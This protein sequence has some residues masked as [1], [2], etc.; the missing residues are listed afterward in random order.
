MSDDHPDADPAA[1]EGPIALDGLAYGIDYLDAVLVFH[2]GDAHLYASWVRA[3]A[4]FRAEDAVATLRDAYRVGQF[5]ARRL[6]VYSA[7]AP[8]R[9]GEALNPLLTLE[10]ASRT[11]ILRR[12]RAHVVACLFESAMPLGMARLV[13]ARLAAA[14]DPELPLDDGALPAAPGAAAAAIQIPRVQEATTEEHSPA[15]LSFG[16]G[17][18]RSLPPQR[19]S[20][21]ELDRT[22]RLLA[23]LDAHAP[24]PHVARLR[25]ALRAGIGLVALDHPETLGPEAVILLETAVEE[26]LG[27][28][29][30]ERRRITA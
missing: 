2:L 1:A 19:I 5:A 12:I 11:A 4:S 27:L 8:E 20:A 18:R 15:T 28:D 13:A 9:R 14:L 3:D 23:H 22:R 17:R 26:I 7:G 29:R 30:V 10:L 24:E 21:A 6:A 16:S 25:L